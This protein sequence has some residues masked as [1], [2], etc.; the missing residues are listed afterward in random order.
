VAPDS[1]AAVTADTPRPVPQPATRLPG[2]GRLW[3]AVAGGQ[4]AWGIAV[5]AAYPM[6]RIGCALGMP[7][8]V[9][10]VRWTA[11]AVAVAATIAG[12]RAWRD[13]RAV[14]RD[15]P[16]RE[17][18]RAVFMGLVGALLS[19]AAFVLLFVEDLATWVIDPCLL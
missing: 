10:A 1:P 13:G 17:A 19:A 3:F 4:A 6:V 9:H 11:M 12:V 16:M 7:L 8:V 15:A 5:L 14:L 2:W 18:Q